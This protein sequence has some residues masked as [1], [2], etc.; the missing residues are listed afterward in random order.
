MRIELNLTKMSEATL[1]DL[2]D[3]M[4]EIDIS[5]PYKA[6]YSDLKKSEFAGEVIMHINSELHSRNP[7]KWPCE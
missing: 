7:E 2:S 1:C 3:S 5:I 6:G 4:H